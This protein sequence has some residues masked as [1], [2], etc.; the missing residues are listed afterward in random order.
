MKL[1]AVHLEGFRGATHRVM[2]KFDSSKLVS[3]LFG[4]NGTGKSSVVDA[5]DFACN[6]S[7]GSLATKSLDG[8]KKHNHLGALTNTPKATPSVEIDVDGAGLT[9]RLVKDKVVVTDK[10][11]G[12]ARPQVSVLRRSMIRQLVDATAAERFGELRSFFSTPIWTSSETALRAACKSKKDE[13]D[14]QSTRL[15]QATFSLKTLWQKQRSPN[16]A[17]EGWA[18]DIL[19][20]PVGDGTGAAIKA[21]DDALNVFS[22]ACPGYRSARVQKQ[23]AIAAVSAATDDAKKA[24]AATKGSSLDLVTLLTG[25]R[26]YIESHDTHGSCPVCTQPM[27][28]EGLRVDLSRRL[29][30]LATLTSAQ[31]AIEQRRA[32]VLTKAASLSASEESLEQAR[33]ALLVAAGGVPVDGSWTEHAASLFDDLIADTATAEAIAARLGVLRTALQP[34]REQVIA[35]EGARSLRDS[36]RHQVDAIAFAR[37]KSDE[38]ASVT[39][40][41]NLWLLELEAARKDLLDTEL[42]SMSSEV[43]AL[44]AR[45]HQGEDKSAF[46][47]AMRSGAISSLEFDAEFLGH[48]G[49]P[50]QAYFSESHLDTLGLCIFLVVAQ[51]NAGKAAIVVLDDV[52]TSIDAAHLD[53]V[54]GL[55]DDYARSVSQVIVATHYRLWRDKYRWGKAPLSQTE[56]I[57]FG[58][59]TLAT[60]IQVQAFQDALTELRILA[61]RSPMDRQVVA[62]KA[63]IVLESILDF[64]TLKYL[65]MLPRNSKAEYTLGTL[66]DG[67][68][69]KLAGVLRIEYSDPTS[70]KA[71]AQELKPLISA[72]TAG[73]WV[74]NAVGCHFTS[75]DSHIPDTEIVQ[76]AATVIALADA[77]ICDGCKTMPDKDKTGSN[78]QCRCGALKLWPHARPKD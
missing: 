62:S 9:A 11:Q 28:H 43:T 65:C 4:E 31:A 58:P 45:I 26:A 77:V 30:E 8:E 55:I 32:T 14:Q 19:G 25:A 40:R 71:K 66:A 56:V 60:G 78:W 70:G 59:W 13:F 72:A 7:F 15:D 23:I 54:M 36:V 10:R 76:F 20:R 5:I 37:K 2:V 68:D 44:Y 39:N 29:E 52:L 75:L 21:L 38:L 6:Q 1:S 74:R 57:E 49:K 24:E 41:L 69:K 51:R 61:P 3:V 73:R 22:L 18:T 34:L 42:A 12:A 47:F 53:R 67:I 17:P 64:L 46:S 50:V 16:G 63:G 48:K 35:A 33:S 27:S